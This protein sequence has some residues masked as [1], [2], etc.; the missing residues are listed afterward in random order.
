MIQKKEMKT[1]RTYKITQ[2]FIFNTRYSSVKIV[3]MWDPE[4]M[5]AMFE[6]RFVKNVWKVSKIESWWKKCS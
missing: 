1:T 5:L 6:A 2:Q 4:Q 3:V